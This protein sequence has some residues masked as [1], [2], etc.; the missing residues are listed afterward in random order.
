MSIRR[1]RDAFAAASCRGCLFSRVTETDGDPHSAH[2]ALD[3]DTLWMD[4]PAEDPFQGYDA[5][6][7]YCELAAGREGDGGA[8]AE[9]RSRITA[10]G[11][12]NLRSRARAAETDLFNLGI[13]FTVYSEANAIDRI[14]PFD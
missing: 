7:F 6:S 5:G 10:L 2:H 14:L 13:T 1:E 12:A 9:I 11:L 4:V 8:A 3:R